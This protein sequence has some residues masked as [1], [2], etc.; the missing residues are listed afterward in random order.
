LYAPAITIRLLPAT[1]YSRTCGAIVRPSA[2]Y[3]TIFFLEKNF[4][5]LPRGQ[6]FA[7]QSFAK[8][9]RDLGVRE[10]GVI[11]NYQSQPGV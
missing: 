2:G 8:A 3:S 5:L 10:S 11:R 1:A 4:A 7:Q 9:L 6:N